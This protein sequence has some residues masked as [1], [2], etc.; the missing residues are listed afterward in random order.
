MKPR[1]GT[2]LGSA[3]DF[4]GLPCAAGVTGAASEARSLREHSQHSLALSA[5]ERDQIPAQETRDRDGIPAK[6]TE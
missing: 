5:A 4:D 6:L 3:G 2:P 1:V